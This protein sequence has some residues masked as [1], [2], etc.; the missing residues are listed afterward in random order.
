VEL[1]WLW[2][3]SWWKS[4]PRPYCSERSHN[5]HNHN[6][7]EETNMQKTAEQFV[8]DGFVVEDDELTMAAEIIDCFNETNESDYRLT[9]RNGRPTRE[10][11]TLVRRIRE[12]PEVDVDEYRRIIYGNFEQPWW[13][14]DGSAEQAGSVAAIFGPRT[15][16]RCRV[17][18]WLP[19][20]EET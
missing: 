11:A 13:Y 5:N 10:L 20:E 3:W 12:S 17:K 15:W 6:D 18:A 19:D 2:W 4:S 7:E 1:N 8:I 9:D 16:A 14:R